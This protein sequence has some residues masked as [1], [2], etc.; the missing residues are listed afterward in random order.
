M[1]A[2]ESGVRLARAWR[3]GLLV[4]CACTLRPPAALVEPHLA[5]VAPA[6]VPADR[7][8]LGVGRFL[9]RRP[10]HERSE[11]RPPLEMHWWGF[12]RVGPEQ[13]GDVSFASAVAEG[14]RRD[15]GSTLVRSGAFS[16]VVW[17]DSDAEHAPE[18][19]ARGDVDWVL[20]AEI[21]ELRGVRHRDF[22]LNVAR[23]GWI[24]RR[25]GQPTGRAT[26]LYRVY[27]ASGEVLHV[28]VAR[29]HTSA[30]STP[31]GAALDALAAANEQAAAEIYRAVVSSSG[32]RRVPLRVLDACGLGQPRAR[33]LVD[34]ASAVFEREIAVRLVAERQ[35]WVP[36]QPGLGLETR[37]EVGLEQLDG[38]EPPDGGLLVALLPVAASSGDA[39]RGLAVPLGRRAV[40]GCRA[41]GEVGALT[42]AHEIG[43]LFG[44]VH[45]ADRASIMFPRAEFEARFFD[46]L[47]HRIL[48]ATRDRD[49]DAPLDPQTRQTLESLYAE[50]RDLEQLVEL[51]DIEAAVAALQTQD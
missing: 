22:A 11:Q 42:L 44:A 17:V 4:L 9:D 12:S 7:P 36:P 27:D 6:D 50:A 29:E 18:R 49:L 34:E 40:L 37:L 14:A 15:A 8:V 39:R 25:D 48:R 5:A 26:L 20:T 16:S 13:S 47:N 1:A 3:L 45:V 43:H 2:P 19:A 41:G 46:P 31:A 30:G 35:A 32:L 23:I 28:R 51:A 10:S 38:V 21:E 24:R 33:A